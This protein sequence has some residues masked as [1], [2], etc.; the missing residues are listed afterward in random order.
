MND[1]VGALVDRM[2][3]EK[4]LTP[5]QAVEVSAILRARF[6]P[7]EQAPAGWLQDV[8]NVTGIALLGQISSGLIQTSEALLS[9]YH[10]RQGIKATIEAAKILSTGKGISPKEFGLANHLI[11]ETVSKRLTGQALSAVLKVNLLTTLDQ[12]GMKQNLTASF[13]KNKRLAATPE[14]QAKLAEKWAPFYEGDFPALIRDLQRS[15]LNE[16]GPLTESLLYGE[17]SDIRPTSRFEMPQLY[18]EH[19]NGRMLW[20]FKQFMLTQADVIRRDAYNLMKSGDANRR[21]RGFKNLALYAAA[22]ATAS[23]PAQIISGWIMGKPLDLDKIDYV[24]NFFKNF[25][26]NR[27]TMDKVKKS[28]TP[29][30]ASVTA[31]KD[32]V[33]PPAVGVA[34]RLGAGVSKPKELLP[35]VPLVGRPI[36]NRTKEGQR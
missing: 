36:Y 33:T 15:T 4:K 2:L 32:T 5:E 21:A 9:L 3:R 29:L 24:E 22:L 25:S 28:K 17:L 7:G 14:G 35:L 8:R 1:S 27:Y 10:H 6:G 18:N 19:P 20:Q 30:K 31:L 26:L 23:V 12:L 34:E 11:E 13:L 16:R